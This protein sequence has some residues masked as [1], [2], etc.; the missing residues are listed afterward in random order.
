VGQLLNFA[1]S[2]CAD[3]PMGCHSLPLTVGT[4]SSVVG[5]F[6]APSARGM[7]DRSTLFSNGLF[8][9]QEVLQGAQDCADG[10]EPAEKSFPVNLGTGVIDVVI[11][12]D[13]CNTRSEVIETLLGFPLAELPFPT[14][15]TIWNPEV[16]M[17]ERGSFVATFEGLFA[18][19]YGVRGDA[20]WQYQLEFGTG[21]PGLTGRQVTIDPT[22]A[23]DPQV[24]EQLE[25][26]ERHAQQG[27]ITAVANGHRLPELRWDPASQVWLA[28]SGWYAES[29]E[30]LRS[31]AAQYNVV[32]T[33]T[34]DLPPNLSIGGADRQP[35]LDVDPDARALEQT[36]DAPTL[37]RPF[38]WDVAT[39]RMGAEYVDPAA[40]ILVDGDLCEV[41]VHAGQRSG[42][43]R[44]RHRH[45]DRPGPRTRDPRR[46]GA[47]PGWVP[48]QR[49]AGLRE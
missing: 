49:D 6:D 8:S 26:I 1:P 19:V 17:T 11:T 32:I 44:Q 14:H 33:V 12:G 36:G 38:E 3:N 30:V 41:L 9:S 22:N 47:E 23:D 45:D 24:I 20:I 39:I 31:H 40:Q 18:L 10:I 35:L 37:P 4:N 29:T 48:E 46:P 21:L 2:T 28:A 15:E 13:P 43:R 25:L 42:D 7:W 27:R 34:A 16:G 5:G